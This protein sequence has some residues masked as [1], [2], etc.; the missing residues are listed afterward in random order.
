MWCD[1]RAKEQ[2]IRMPDEGP[3]NSRG[4]LVALGII[5]LIVVAAVILIRELSA[6]SRLQDCLLAGR[7]NC[8][9]ITPA[10]H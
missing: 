3:K 6:S 7:S 8:A 2:S 1:T 5:V 10:E 9:P 4:P